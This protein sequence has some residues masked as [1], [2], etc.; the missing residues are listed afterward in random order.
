M[1]INLK[2]T[3]TMK[4]SYLSGHIKTKIVQIAVISKEG[5]FPRTSGM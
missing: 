3:T 5:A 1:E 2:K 4:T